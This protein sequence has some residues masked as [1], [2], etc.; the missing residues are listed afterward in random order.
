MAKLTLLMILILFMVIST[1]TAMNPL[2]DI[3]KK[4]FGHHKLVQFNY[5]LGQIDDDS[6][7]NMV[8]IFR[9]NQEEFVGSLE[10]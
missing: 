8:D 2:S 7:F 4:C 9:E 1:L 10:W 6:L 3:I 5:M